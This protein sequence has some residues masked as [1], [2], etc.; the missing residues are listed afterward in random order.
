M[1]V[2]CPFIGPEP[3][4]GAFVEPADGDADVADD[5]EA[6]VDEDVD[7]DV[8]AL[9]VDAGLPVAASATPVT[10]APRPAAT[11]PVMT[12]RPARPVPNA[13]CASFPAGFPGGSGRIR[14]GTASAASTRRNPKRCSQSALS[15]RPG[16]VLSMP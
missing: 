9:V 14:P 16:A 6:G 13:L 5:A 15:N 8:A 4:D 3:D 12:R 10:P 2:Q 7:E 11:N 1:C